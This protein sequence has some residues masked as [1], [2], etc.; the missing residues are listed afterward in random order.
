MRLPGRILGILAALLLLATPASLATTYVVHADGTGDFPTIQA[1]IDAAGAGD[2]IELSDGTF[3]SAGNRDVDFAGK[4]LEVRSQS[5][6]P[7]ACVIDCAAGPA[8]PHRGF[9]FQSGEGSGSVLRGVTIQ[10]GYAFAP[11]GAG[12]LCD[13]ASPSITGC[14]LFAN[15]AVDLGGGLLCLG[16]AAPG[17]TDCMFLENGTGSGVAGG[18]AACLSASPSF[19]DCTFQANLCQSGGGLYCG[20]HASPTLTGCQFEG[21]SATAGGTGYG[22][23]LFAYHHSS[24]ALTDCGFLEND[25][26]L[27]AG[28]AC[29]DYCDPTFD[30]CRFTNNSASA[31]GG[32]Y[33]LYYCFPT[34]FECTFWNNEADTYGGALWSGDSAPEIERCTLVGDSAGIDGGGLHCNRS[35]PALENTIIAFGR[36]GAAVYCYDAGTTVVLSCCD[37]YGNAGGDWVGCIASQSGTSGNI[38]LDPHFCDAGSGNFELAQ[39]SPCA[40]FTAP[41][42]EC[43]RI[44]AWPVGCTSGIADQP[45][46]P[47]D[48]PG[49]D[50]D[51][52]LWCVPHPIKQEATLRFRIPRRLAGAAVALEILDA[53]GRAVRSL[54]PDRGRAG[55]G[56][57]ESPAAADGPSGGGQSG[58]ITWDGR[59]RAGH[60][61]PNGIY[62]ARLRVG[63]L[64]ETRPLR[65]VR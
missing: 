49:A 36:G 63:S 17:V 46:L 30:G 55:P 65:L 33:F 24:P 60:R 52:S 54:V 40:P 23:G 29:H 25:G 11:G 21:N 16:G 57:A 56:A 39:D 13:G 58:S 59:D 61:L 14:W 37:I 8:D 22:G 43:D 28:M 47:A 20:D 51:L 7:F 4:A 45:I 38:S 19:T 31:G 26:A 32:T 34:L 42:P 18:G 27:G 9:V 2:V 64:V 5:G 6:T 50:P 10:H 44:G 3:T 62:F 53:S 15:H 35:D 48:L 1:A 41:N 12:I